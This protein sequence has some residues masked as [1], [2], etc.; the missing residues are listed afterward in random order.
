MGEGGIFFKEIWRLLKGLKWSSLKGRLRKWTDMKRKCVEVKRM[1]ILHDMR[2]DDWLKRTGSIRKKHNITPNR[3]QYH[4][5]VAPLEVLAWSTSADMKSWSPWLVVEELFCRFFSR[6][7]FSLPARLVWLSKLCCRWI[8]HNANHMGNGCYQADAHPDPKHFEGPGPLVPMVTMPFPG[9]ALLL[10]NSPHWEDGP[11]CDTGFSFNSSYMIWRPLRPCTKSIITG[12]KDECDWVARYYAKLS[13]AVAKT[14]DKK[15]Q[16]IQRCLHLVQLVVQG[17][18]AQGL[19]WCRGRGGRAKLV[20]HTVSRHGTAT[21]T[22]S[23]I[24]TCGVKKANCEN[25]LSSSRTRCGAWCCWCGAWC[26]WGDLVVVL[27]VLVLLLC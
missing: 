3:L 9:M 19:S 13:D 6:E 26:C 14:A 1:E 22:P 8:I 24:P 2:G 4:V 17:H 15:F 21:T 16:D 11:C 7:S 5:L 10:S 27:L 23:L 25:G 20:Q 18:P 12:W